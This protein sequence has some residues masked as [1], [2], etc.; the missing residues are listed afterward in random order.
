MVT[1]D[2]PLIF[3]PMVSSTDAFISIGDFTEYCE[4]VGF[5]SYILFHNFYTEFFVKENF[6]S[7]TLKCFTK[8]QYCL[9]L[10]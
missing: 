4:N 7:S 2:F 5:L 8:I 10:S 9:G 3:Y 6:F 1:S